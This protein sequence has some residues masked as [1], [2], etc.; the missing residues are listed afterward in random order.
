MENQT[1]VIP[2]QTDMDPSTLLDIA[3]EIAER[4]QSEIESYG[5]EVEIDEHEVYVTSGE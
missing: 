4:L 1:I 5:N 3:M 2:V